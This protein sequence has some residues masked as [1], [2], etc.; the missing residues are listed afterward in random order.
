MQAARLLHDEKV[1]DQLAISADR[2]ST[3]AGRTAHEV[4]VSQI[5]HNSRRTRSA[6]TRLDSEPEYS[7]TAARQCLR[8]IRQNRRRSRCRP[9]HGRTGLAR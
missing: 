7:V 4:C 2:L 9:H 6:K 5:G 1:V 8:A 3:H